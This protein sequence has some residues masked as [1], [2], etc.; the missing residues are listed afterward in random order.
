MNR[1]NQISKNSAVICTVILSLCTLRSAPSFAAGAVEMQVEHILVQTI[2]EYNQAMETGDS[3]G[4]MKNFSD[5]VQ[6]RSPV[7]E[8][9]GKKDVG[10]YF[11][12]EFKNFQ[13]KYVTKKIIV[14]GRSAAIVFVW[15]AVHKASGTPLK[16]E[17]VG[18]FDLASSGRFDNVSFYFDTANTGKFFAETATS[19]K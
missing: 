11:A 13:A 15:D 4:L 14:S 12:W 16:I 19:V 17:M 9:T 5:N 18:I 7:S 2:E 8:Q 1:I 6:R 3:S 10:D